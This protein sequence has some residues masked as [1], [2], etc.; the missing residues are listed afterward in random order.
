MP[1]RDEYIAITVGV[2]LTLPAL[3]IACRGV[4]LRIPT[5]AAEDS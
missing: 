2:L 1:N 5:A 4:Y 3:A